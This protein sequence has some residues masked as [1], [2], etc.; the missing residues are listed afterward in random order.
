VGLD[1][2]FIV[3]FGPD[4]KLLVLSAQF[5]WCD[6]FYGSIQESLMRSC[7]SAF[8]DCMKKMSHLIQLVEEMH[9]KIFTHFN[10][11]INCAYQ[12][13]SGRRRQDVN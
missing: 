10:K 1:F 12:I 8:E 13:P 6:E 2:S 5:F 4:A 9:K 3:S 11:C 7:A